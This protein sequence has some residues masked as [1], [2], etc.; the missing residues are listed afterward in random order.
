MTHHANANESIRLFVANALEVETR[1]GLAAFC[2]RNGFPHVFTE[3]I[4]PLLGRSELVFSFAVL[5]RP[6]PPK[7]VGSQTLEAFAVAM[8][9]HERRAHL[10]PVIMDRR[11]ATN[12]GL[13]CAVTKQLFGALHERRVSSCGYVVRQGEPALERALA[14]A[15]FARADLHVATEFA[16]YIEYTTQPAKALDALGLAGMRVGDLM[17]GSLKANELDA[18]GAYHFTLGA[19]LAPYLH[20]ELR[21]AAVLAGLIDLVA[22]LPPG[23][24]PPGTPGPELGDLGG[25]L[26]EE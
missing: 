8:I 14:R 4:E 21:Y 23:G 11:H 12:I 5:D 24:V 3:V 1:C 25:G 18:L 13:A 26:V 7:G 19:A 20:D 6:W 10:T 17:A 15:S 16:E 22:S 2:R 9:G